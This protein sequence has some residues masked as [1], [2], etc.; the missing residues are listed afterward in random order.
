MPQKQH[1]KIPE[2][3]EMLSNLK[4]L[5]QQSEV[6]GYQC[7]VGALIIRNIADI[8]N[9]S[10]D[11]VYVQKRSANRKLFPDCWDILGGH[12][13]AGETL[14]IA[15][16]REIKEE[17]GWTLKQIVQHLKTVE[18]QNNDGQTIKEFVFLVTVAGDLDNPVLEQDKFSEFRWVS[19][20][21]LAI[22]KE[23]RLEGEE[24]IFEL[25]SLA[26]EKKVL[27]NSNL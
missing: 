26:L 13:D 25:A 5:Q 15:L 23:N 12:V 21:D 2:M 3:P 10:Q 22:L 6:A 9:M 16:T 27:D 4:Q 20:A 18:W 14:E 11:T 1:S 24:L 7:V 8:E 19:K 17:S